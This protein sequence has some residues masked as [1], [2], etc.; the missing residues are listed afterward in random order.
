MGKTSGEKLKMYP[1]RRSDKVMNGLWLLGG[2][3]EQKYDRTLT[4]IKKKKVM[5]SNRKTEIKVE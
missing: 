4:Y 2:K 3:K 5:R 1:G